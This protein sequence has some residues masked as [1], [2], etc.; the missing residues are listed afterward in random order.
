MDEKRCTVRRRS[1]SVVDCEWLRVNYK[2]TSMVEMTKVLNRDADE[3]Y[4]KAKV[5]GFPRKCIS[6]QVRGRTGWTPELDQWLCEHYGDSG[7]SIE[8]LAEVEGWHTVSGIKSRA[9]QLNIAFHRTTIDFE[10]QWSE[11]NVHRLH[12]VMTSVENPQIYD[13]M[14]STQYSRSEVLRKAQ[15]LGYDWVKLA[16]TSQSIPKFRMHWTKME[17]SLLL[18]VYPTMDWKDKDLYFPGLDRR[19]VAN[20]ASRL[21]IKRI[22][23][24]DTYAGNGA[25]LSLWTED[26]IDWMKNHLDATCEEMQRRFPEKTRSQIYAKRTAVATKEGI[27]LS[28]R[29]SKVS[30]PPTCFGKFSVE[31]LKIIAAHIYDIPSDVLPLLGRECSE[32]SVSV[33]QRKLRFAQSILNSVK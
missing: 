9:K 19:N 6:A 17:E 8:E 14:Q 21:G 11:V 25:S 2:E 33:A 5:Y 30:T 29:K 10:C 13:V 15:E 12:E 22:I 18:H 26:E 1:W 3:I 27:T 28:E 32:Y 7:Y 20:V 31:E 23:T 16:S 4:E 24:E